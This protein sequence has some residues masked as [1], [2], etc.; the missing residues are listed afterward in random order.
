MVDFPTEPPESGNPKNRRVVAQQR[1]RDF[2]A[3]LSEGKTPFE[4]Y[5]KVFEIPAGDP[6]LRNAVMLANRLM[7]RADVAKLMYNANRA[8]S[9]GALDPKLGEK[10]IENLNEIAFDKDVK[11]S[12]RTAASIGA[13]RA[14]GYFQKDEVKEQHLTINMVDFSGNTQIN[15]AS[16]GHVEPVG[17]ECHFALP[18]RSSTIPTPVLG[19]LEKGSETAGAGESPTVG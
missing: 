2:V 19:S 15:S 16:S 18:L 8:I 11:P 12:E 4:A 9:S 1:A 3:A 13:L 6:R 10:H 17:G 14:L 5:V 7:N